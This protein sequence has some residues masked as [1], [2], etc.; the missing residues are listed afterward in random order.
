MAK[1]RAEVLAKAQAMA[2]A[3][4]AAASGSTP[5]AGA[6]MPAGG[7]P[8]MDAIRQRAEALKARMASL[9]KVVK[10]QSG[11]ILFMVSLETRSLV[12]TNHFFLWVMSQ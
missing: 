6:P 4:A 2:A 11:R 7:V 3:R 10:I 8:N 9:S 1:A 12:L 5:T